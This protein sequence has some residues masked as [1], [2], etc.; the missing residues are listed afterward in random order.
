[1]GCWCLTLSSRTCLG[2]ISHLAF[3]NLNLIKSCTCKGLIATLLNSFCVRSSPGTMTTT[4]LGSGDAYSVRREEEGRGGNRGSRHRPALTASD[5][6]THNVGHSSCYLLCPG[7]LATSTVISW[8]TT[9]FFTN[10]L[11]PHIMHLPLGHAFKLWYVESS[12]FNRVCKFRTKYIFDVS[13]PADGTL[14]SIAKSFQMTFL[15]SRTIW[16][17][18]PEYASGRPAVQRFKSESSRSGVV[19]LQSQERTRS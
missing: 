13:E 8:L 10:N 1:M 3:C 12:F 15:S 6:H 4:G 9:T 17:T 2:L 18:T 19:S 14:S 16:L 7:I 11:L 5:T